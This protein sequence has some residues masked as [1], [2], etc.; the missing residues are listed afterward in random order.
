MTELIL[1]ANYADVAEQAA[2]PMATPI[3]QTN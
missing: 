1:E 3:W 2:R